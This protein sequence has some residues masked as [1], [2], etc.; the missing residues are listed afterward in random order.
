[1]DG[2]AWASPPSIGADEVIEA[3]LVGPISLSVNAW[4]TNTFAGS[5]H[6]LTFWASITGRVSRIDWNF[7]DGVISTNQGQTSPIH[8]WTNTGNFTVTCTAYNTD[9]PSGVSASVNIQVL[10][11]VSPTIH[12]SSV[13]SNGFKFSFE[14]QENGRYTVQ[15]ATN[16]VAPV[17]WITLQTIFYSLGGATQITDPAW[18]NSARFYRVLVQ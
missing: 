10:P 15:Y 2:E 3:N 1:M 14:A 11:L 18:T 16:L 9:N 13:S 5:Y 17:T 7:G 4:Q 8:W 12:S 6:A